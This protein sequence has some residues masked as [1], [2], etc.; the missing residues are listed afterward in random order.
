MQGKEVP[1]L[2]RAKHTFFPR[3][4]FL[5]NEQASSQA[6][7]LRAFCHQSPVGKAAAFQLLHDLKLRARRVWLPSRHSY[8]SLSFPLPSRCALST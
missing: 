3:W 2:E 8:V 4:I 1:V 7:L 6:P 5:D